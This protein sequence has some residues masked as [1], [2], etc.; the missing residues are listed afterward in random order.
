M[1][2]PVLFPALEQTDKN[3]AVV[4]AGRGQRPAETQPDN[5]EVVRKS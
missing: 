4:V 2:F 5:N 3:L 1:S